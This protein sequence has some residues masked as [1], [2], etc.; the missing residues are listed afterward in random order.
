M[1]LENN[2]FQ[3]QAHFYPYSIF[4]QIRKTEKKVTFIFKK[5]KF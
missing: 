2:I 3:I 4:A 1:L 5:L